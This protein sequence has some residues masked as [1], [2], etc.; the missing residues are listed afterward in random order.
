MDVE[1]LRLAIDRDAEVPIGV[2]LAWALRALI[3]DGS[4]SAGDRL[5]GLREVADA[6]GLNVNTVRAVYARL[7]QEGLIDSRQGSG[8]F[9][10]DAAAVSVRARAIA[11]NA[12]R[13]AHATGVD[14]RAVAAALYVAPGG[15]STADT[16]DAG[17]RRRELRSQIA[18]L[19]R[20][21]GELESEHPDITPAAARAPRAGG[22]A[23]LSIS[24][25]E[26]VRA[27][28]VRRLASAQAAIDDHLLAG[29]EPRAA[30]ARASRTR[31][32]RT[33]RRAAPVR[34]SDERTAK[35][36]QRAPAGKPA[37]ARRAP[38][39]VRPATAET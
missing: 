17:A 30:S 13:E 2:Q 6:T 18:V 19:E 24:D 27:A 26:Q 15:P 11:A 9:V 23:L 31:A 39:G 4:A 32:Q 1:E 35:G 3:G 8:T 38:R 10:A 36:S 37:R 28:L 21:I 25:L 22:A 7:D 12:A 20:A 14:P 29:A 34:S 16:G 33:P 5:P